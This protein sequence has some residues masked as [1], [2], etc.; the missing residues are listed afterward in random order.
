MLTVFRCLLLLSDVQQNNELFFSNPRSLCRSV[1]R[2]R[3]HQQSEVRKRNKEHCFVITSRSRCRDKTNLLTCVF[4]LRAHLSFLPS[5]ALDEVSRVLPSLVMVDRAS[6]L[7]KVAAHV[8]GSF[9]PKPDREGGGETADTHRR[10][11]VHEWFNQIC[12]TVCFWS[13]KPIGRWCH[14]LETTS[15]PDYILLF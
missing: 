14:Q 8:T 9:V 15:T 3:F 12:G 4:T 6:P 7:P 13:W 11:T 2:D 5:S 1:T 10:A